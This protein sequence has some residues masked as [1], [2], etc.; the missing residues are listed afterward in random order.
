[1]T[2]TTV[3]SVIKLPESKLI[4]IVLPKG[5]NWDFE[6]IGIKHTQY[7]THFFHHWAAKFIPQIPQNIIRKYG[8]PGDIVLDPFVG[9]GTTLVEAKLSG[10]PSYGIDINPLAIRICQAKVKK[11]NRDLLDD[12]IF[13]LDHFN[14]EYKKHIEKG[15]LDLFEEERLPENPTLFPN[16]NK[17][18]RDDVA[19]CIKFILRK[20]KEFDASTKNF[21][22]IGISDLLKGLSN[23]R[24]D[25][26]MPCLPKSNRYY[27]K[28]HE[29]WMDN[30]TRVLNVFQRLLGQLKR[31]RFALE[32]FQRLTKEDLDCEPILGD[33][34]CLSKFIKKANIVVTSPPYWNAQN[35]QKLHLLSFKV[36]KLPEPGK[37]EI[38]RKV[39]SYLDDIE[40]VIKELR[41]ILDGIFAIVIGES[42]DDI[43]NQ[44]KHLILKQGMKEEKI[45]KRNIINHTF[46]AKSV[47][48]EFIYIFRNSP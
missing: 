3:S 47:Q 22:E 26:T 34:R 19:R 36:L 12:F 5:N 17:W 30:E 15:Q 11:I 33:A 21:I 1:M 20:I 8:K 44:I 35:Y 43:H 28:K 10:C 14:R 4:G 38:G 13:W 24:S 9:C 45:I 32:E 16:S 48:Q 37:P 27:D 7:L 6:E 2:N 42:K 46:F 41:K 25:R 29:R 40:T 23:A 31:M 39:S 18:F